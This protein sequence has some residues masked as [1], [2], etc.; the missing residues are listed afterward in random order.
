MTDTERI[1]FMRLALDEARKA[2]AR[3]DGPIGCVI[4]H[5]GEVVARAGNQSVTT[6]C[7]LEHAEMVA[8]RGA[9]DYF[10]A[11]GAECVLFTTFEP[12]VMCMGAI[13]IARIGAVVY[14]EADPQRGGAE[15][16]AHVPYVTRAL[17]SYRGGILAD[18]CAQLR[19]DWTRPQPTGRVWTR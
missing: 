3:G 2:L 8:I 5:H 14:G 1:A 6:G 16:F 18:E 19:A 7:K 9:A 10:D 17:T 15:A 4:V 11:N 13:A 12:C